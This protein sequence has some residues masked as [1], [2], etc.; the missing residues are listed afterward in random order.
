MAVTLTSSAVQLNDVF[1]ISPKSKGHT[2]APTVNSESLLIDRT[3]QPI[4]KKRDE[5]SFQPVTSNS[6]LS[7]NTTPRSNATSDIVM[8]SSSKTTADVMPSSASPISI[9]KVLC[10]QQANDVLPP[11]SDPGNLLNSKPQQPS[12]RFARA[13]MAG[14]FDRAVDT[15]ELPKGWTNQHDRAICYL[16]YRGYSLEDSITKVRNYFP[17]LDGKLSTAM[18]DTRLRQLD[19]IVEIT[20]WAEA[21]RHIEEANREESPRGTRVM[22]TNPAA[23]IQTA[24]VQNL[25]EGMASVSPTVRVSENKHH[26]H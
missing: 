5:G 8:P 12:P 14:A 17:E 19:Q 13:G 26:L 22:T 15:P 21:M 3:N 4:S 10:P 16:D 18:I 1:G 24:S 11:I 9:E 7:I 6:T 25:R 23:M 20:Y 2:V